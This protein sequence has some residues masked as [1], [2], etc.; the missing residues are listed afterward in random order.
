[1]RSYVKKSFNLWQSPVNDKIK[2]PK[3]DINSNKLYYQ[4]SEEERETYYEYK[5][6]E[7]YASPLLKSCERRSERS[8]GSGRPKFVFD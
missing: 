6:E 1:M 2:E 7:T 4:I 3:Y 5:L 8:F